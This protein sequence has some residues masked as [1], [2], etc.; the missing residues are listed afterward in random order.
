MSLYLEKVLKN[1][2][3]KRVRDADTYTCTFACSRERRRDRERMKK[4]K[5]KAYI[6]KSVYKL[7][8]ICMATFDTTRC[9]VYAIDYIFL[10][11]VYYRFPHVP[12][13]FK[14]C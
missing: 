3:G 7:I 10:L 4:K 5:K 2:G 13:I 1:G 14:E 12:I 8:I 9:F 6:R 11:H